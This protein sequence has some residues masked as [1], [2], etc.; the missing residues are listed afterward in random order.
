MKVQ[1]PQ[2]LIRWIGYI[3]IV[4]LLGPGL[5]V[6]MLYWMDDFALLQSKEVDAPVISIERQM[7]QQR[8]QE[9]P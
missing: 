7:D 3:L 8:S 4:A 6:M 2:K 5:I 1:K 9:A